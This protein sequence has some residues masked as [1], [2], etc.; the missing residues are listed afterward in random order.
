LKKEEEMP[1]L[2]QLDPSRI[3]QQAYDLERTLRDLVVGQD[4]AIREIVN[5][6]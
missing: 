5:A 3:G 1:Q 2:V 4:Q 6:Y